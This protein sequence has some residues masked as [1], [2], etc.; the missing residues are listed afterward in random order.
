MIKVEGTLLEAL[1]P[2]LALLCS[3]SAAL[4][5]LA[6]CCVGCPAHHLLMPR[7]LSHMSSPHQL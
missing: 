3:L 5:H 4:Q 6:A 2:G 7:V 1:K